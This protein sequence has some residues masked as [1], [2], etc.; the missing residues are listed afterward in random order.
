MDLLDFF[1]F[2]IYIFI[3]NFIFQ[4]RRKRYT[5]PLLRKYHRN[6]FWIKVFSCFAYSMFVLHFS[7][8]DSTYLFF[9]EGHNIYKLILK[10]PSNITMLF[11]PGKEFDQ[12]LLANPYNLGYFSEDANYMVAKIVAFL[13][14]LTLVKFLAISLIFS[15]LSFTGVWRLYLFFYEQYP[16][17]HKQF[18][19]AILYL[20]M[21]VFW[22]SGILKDPLCTGAL[23]WFTYSLFH[24][25]YKR[26]NLL[27]DVI[28]VMISSYFLVVLKVY[29]IVSYLPFFMLFLIL[30]NVTLIKS[31]FAK[32]SLV[33][34][35]LI[36]SMVGF[37]QLS[38]NTEKALGNFASKG[39]TNSIITY[40]TNY[41][42]QQTEESS[43]F[44]LGVEYDGSMRSLLRMAPAAIIATLYRPFI[45]ESRKISTLFSSIESL[46]IMLFTVSVF[47]RVGFKKTFKTIV[48]NPIIMYCLLF[49]LIFALFVGATTLNFGTLVRYKIPAMPFYVSALFLIVYYNPKAQKKPGIVPGLVVSEKS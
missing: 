42:A 22:S 15:M 2:V 24:I 38:G 40:Q 9:P 1:I 12:S 47:Y 48:S 18:A 14:F 35:F 13:S 39:L 44:S 45:W 28:I 33:L 41:V 26:Q 37:T 10:D 11:I 3:F 46:I 17:L 30:K 34:S 29:I 27:K 25:F 49:S 21:F 8:G 23:G 4:L 7:P 31:K 43:S 32:V 16:Q 20:P 19:I 36:G 6:A 5:D